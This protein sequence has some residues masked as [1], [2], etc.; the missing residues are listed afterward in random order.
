MSSWSLSKISSSS[1]ACLVALAGLSVILGVPVLLETLFDT[2]LD[3]LLDEG[4]ERAV[5]LS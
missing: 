3:T 5:F 4:T 2:L 1:L